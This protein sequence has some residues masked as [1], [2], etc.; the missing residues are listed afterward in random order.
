LSN[1]SLELHRNRFAVGIGSLEELP[2]L[3]SE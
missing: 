2:L 1:I 3:E